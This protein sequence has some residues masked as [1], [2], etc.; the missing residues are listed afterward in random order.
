MLNLPVAR[1]RQKG[2]SRGNCRVDI[3]AQRAGLL[4]CYTSV[5]L[6]GPLL[7]F[8]LLWAGGWGEG[9]KGAVTQLR[10]SGP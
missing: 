5:G 4:T 9:L 1:H 2:W 7:W 10:P 6:S 8:I 3:R